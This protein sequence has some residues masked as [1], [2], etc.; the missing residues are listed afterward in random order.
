MNTSSVVPFYFQSHEVRTINIENN[1]WFVAKDVCDIL[2][3]EHITNALGRIP[4]NHLTVIRL[5]SGGQMRDM[6]AVSEPGLYRLIL[7]SDKPQAEP[8]M[9]WVTAEVLPTIR[10]TG[11]YS[12]PK[13]DKRIYV[14]HAHSK[15]T[16]APG[17]LDIRYTLDL[18][19]VVA[20]PTRRSIELLERL[21]GIQLADITLQD[22]KATDVSIAEVME[23]YRLHC[24]FA[25]GEKETFARVYAAYRTYSL[26]LGS[27][28]AMVASK[29]RFSS[30]L[31][32]C[33]FTV[34]KMSGS[35]YLLDMRL[36]EE[37]VQ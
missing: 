7:R 37:V 9:E 4:E 5:Q 35:A 6:K 32:A 12:L 19:K 23:F 8:F 25:S 33:G 15:T 24:R 30:L 21:T 31:G 3:L 17:G 10:K 34:A 29:K 22:E 36:I 2:G 20:N 27:I 1:P 11:S 18:G 28:P 13:N 14:N 26:S 16:N